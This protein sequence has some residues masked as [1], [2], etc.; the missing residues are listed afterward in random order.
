MMQQSRR[1][2][3][4][5]NEGRKQKT[6]KPFPDVKTSFMSVNSINYEQRKGGLFMK[7][8]KVCRAIRLSLCAVLLLT[9]MI[10]CGVAGATNTIAG[11][12]TSFTRSS[13]DSAE[14]YVHA[15]CAAPSK[16]V[17]KV[18]LESAEQGSTDY[19]QAARTVKK[20]VYNSTTLTQEI[21]YDIDEDLDYR[22]KIEVTDT[23]NGISTTV[24]AYRYLEDP[25][26]GL[27]RP[28]Q[29]EQ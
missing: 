12:T 24:T 14:A 10:P 13:T 29:S 1:K 7:V 15:V 26:G 2:Y 8:R 11:L 3:N 19:E 5:N 23:Y 25:P 20:T 21:G 9:L 4:F 17:S 16:I 28:Q 18:T 22:I 6:G 27:T